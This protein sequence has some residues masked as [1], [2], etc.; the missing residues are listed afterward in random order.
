MVG[1]LI[2]NQYIG[3]KQHHTRQHA[4]NL[5]AAGQDVYRLVYIVAGK[6]HLA[7]E[8][9]KGRFQCVGLR[10]RSQPIQHTLGVSIEELRV[11]LR[12]I[13]LAGGNAP[14]E[15]AFIRL[16]FTHQ[17]LEQRGCR[18]LCLADKGNFITARDTERYMIEYLLAVNGLGDV[19]DLQN[20][21]ARLSVHL[22]AD[23]RIAAGGCRQLVNRQLV[24]E[25]FTAGCLLRLGFIGGE[26]TDKFLQFLDFF[27]CLL[28]LVVQGALYQLRGLIP[29]FVVADIQT[30]LAVVNIYDVRADIVEEVTVMGYN[31]DCALVICQKI[32]QPCNRMNIQMVGRLVQQHNIRLAKQ[33]LCQQDLD[34]FCVRA[35]LHAAVQNIIRL[36]SQTLQQT[37]CLCVCIPAVQLGKLRFQFSGAVAI[38]F[39]KRVLCVQRVFLLHDFI[40]TRIALNNGIYDGKVIK[41]KVI[42]TQHRHAQL[43]IKLHRAGRRL[44]IA[45]QHPQERGLACAV[46]ADDSIAIALCKF[47]IDIGEQIVSIKVNAQ[48][49]DGK[50]EKPPVKT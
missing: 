23:K 8:R 44:Q 10:I 12:E 5:L 41:G 27:I 20:V 9:A 19:L 13:R 30:N 15:A 11:V 2:D 39:R 37:S 50:H 6:Q 45:G 35:V 46:R 25:L 29:E 40:Q 17:N 43:R 16:Q 24:N 7:Q 14:L 49:I 22:E 28:F 3:T 42:L 18:L 34:L 4:A 21:L 33:C 48:M 32:L 36:E 1:R 31:D 47:Q 26:S 38:L